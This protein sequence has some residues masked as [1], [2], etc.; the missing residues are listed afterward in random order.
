MEV[1]VGLCFLL[2]AREQQ[3]YSGFYIDIIYR[4]EVIKGRTFVLEICYRSKESKVKGM[5]SMWYSENN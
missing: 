2:S 5:T 1:S 4:A 3:I